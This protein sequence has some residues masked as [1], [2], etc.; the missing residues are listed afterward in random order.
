MKGTRKIRQ[1]LTLTAAALT[2]AVLVTVAYGLKDGFTDGLITAMKRCG[3]PALTLLLTSA[4][5]AL[6]AFARKK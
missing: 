3:Y 1:V 4:A 5:L 2:I 6:C